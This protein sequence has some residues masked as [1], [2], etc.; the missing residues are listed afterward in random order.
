MSADDISYELLFF[1][2][3]SA[4]L[5]RSNMESSFF[6]VKHVVRLEYKICSL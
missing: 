6:S 1:C 4:K 3:R 2:R 5:S